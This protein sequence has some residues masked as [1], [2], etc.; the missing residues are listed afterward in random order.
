MTVSIIVFALHVQVL[1][2][3]LSDSGNGKAAIVSEEIRERPDGIVDYTC[4]IRFVY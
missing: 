1:Q 2:F 3:S 4:S